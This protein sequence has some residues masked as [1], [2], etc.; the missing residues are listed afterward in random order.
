M[1]LGGGHTDNGPVCFR[2]CQTRVGIKRHWEKSWFSLRYRLW[3]FSC[4]QWSCVFKKRR[5]HNAFGGIFSLFLT[6]TQLKNESKHAQCR[7]EKTH[8][9]GTYCLWTSSGRIDHHPCMRHQF[10]PCL[11]GG[12]H[13]RLTYGV[14]CD[15]KLEQ[16][17]TV[18]TTSDPLLWC[19]FDYKREASRSEGRRL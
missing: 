15:P 9:D 10:P 11:M 4:R 6:E 5:K 7:E 14:S 19:P 16:P 12:A 1:A 8:I 2:C 13:V 17:N 18:Q 3:C